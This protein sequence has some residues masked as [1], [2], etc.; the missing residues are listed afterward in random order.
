MVRLSYLGLGD[1]AACLRRFEALRPFVADL[2]GLQRLCAPGQGDYLAF[3]VAIDALETAAFHFTRR[4][5][6][7]EAQKQAARGGVHP[8]LGAREA[9]VATFRR[10]A[11]YRDALRG[12]QQACKPFGRDY[13]A[14]AIAISGFDTLAF[15]FTR[16]AQFYAAPMCAQPGAPAR[17]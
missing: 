8:G 6:F 17:P 13:Q 5:F 16:D 14:M 4:P 15:H 1:P 10:L 9:L 3:E 2:R 7:F 11:A 12:L